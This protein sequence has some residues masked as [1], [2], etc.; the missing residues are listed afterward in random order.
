MDM[1]LSGKTALITG[2]ASGLGRESARY[3]V[4]EGVRIVIADQNEV[5]IHETVA[6]LQSMEGEATGFALDVRDY[7]ANESLA[8]FAVDT[9]GSLD[10][11]IAGAGVGGGNQFFVDTQPEDWNPILDINV[12]GV[13]NTNRAVAPYMI[14]QGSGSII[15]IA[16][17]AGK[18]GEKRIVAYAASKGAVMSFSKALATEMGRYHIRVNAVCPGVTRTAMTAAKFGNPGDETYDRSAKFYPLG[19]LGEPEDIASVITLLASEQSGWVTGQCISING[20]FG[21]S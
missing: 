2:G 8:R 12:R 17:E 7:A 4:R 9:F 13:M 5:H 10:V 14:E 19:R 20:G 21:R 6:E 18:V 1:H 15:N 11:V 16:S 3:L